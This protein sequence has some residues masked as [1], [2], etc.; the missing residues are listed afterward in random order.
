[1]QNGEYIQDRWMVKMVKE[2]CALFGAEVRLFS[3]DWVLE[4]AKGGK[5]SFIFGY[6]FGLNDSAAANIAQDKVAMYQ[7]LAAHDVASVE[8]YL[9]RTADAGSWSRLPLQKDI[10][11]KPLTGTGGR[12]IEL[13]G[14]REIAR[15]RI[16]KSDIEAWALSPYYNITREIRLVILDDEILL[17]YEKQPVV[18]GGMKFFNL[19][20]GAVPIAY[21]PT[22]PQKRMAID[23]MRALGLRIGAVDAIECADGRTMILE[24]NDGVMMENF[25][26]YSEANKQKTAE[27][28][29]IIV[30]AQ[31]TLGAASKEKT[32]SK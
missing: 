31:L 23:A 7:V 15:E 20:L 16:K 22:S 32:V 1:M 13:C 8:H 10:I 25:A 4:V 11:I 26:R 27:I 2:A 5:E 6:K 21:V 17:S 28:Y 12:G 29:E 18:R 24:V 3:D 30:K 14:D 9:V 19:G